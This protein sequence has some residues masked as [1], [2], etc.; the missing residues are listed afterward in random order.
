[1]IWI[2]YVKEQNVQE[3]RRISYA[4]RGLNDDLQKKVSVSLDKRL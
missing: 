3:L 1:M 2:L 4:L